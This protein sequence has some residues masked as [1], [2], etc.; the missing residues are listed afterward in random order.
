L[1]VPNLVL[2]FRLLGSKCREEEEEEEEF[3]RVAV[4]DG[5]MKT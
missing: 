1:I 4:I 2:R 3:A 5:K